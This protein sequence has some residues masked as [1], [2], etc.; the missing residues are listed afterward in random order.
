MNLFLLQIVDDQL[1]LKR[2]FDKSLLKYVKPKINVFVKVRDKEAD[3]RSIVRKFTVRVDESGEQL[4][5]VR[6]RS[7]EDQQSPIYI[8]YAQDSEVLIKLGTI[9][10]NPD[11]FPPGDFDVRLNTGKNV[12][13]DDQG[14]LFMPV[15]PLKE[16]NATNQD[17][18]I[19]VNIFDKKQNINVLEENFD[20]PLPP[21]I[22]GTTPA[23]SVSPSASASPSPS[24][25]ANASTPAASTPTTPAAVRSLFSQLFSSSP[26]TVIFPNHFFSSESKQR[27]PSGSR[28]QH[29]R[30]RA[31]SVR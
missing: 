10:L 16:L 22:D 7:V 27:V 30:Q 2:K 23:P 11:T 29:E 26:L 4:P 9:E 24:A 12:S 31:Q 8:K 3:E 28:L 19:T 1:V 25:S 21:I 14:N 6:F 15:H 20:I 18:L 5:P 13:L 17:A